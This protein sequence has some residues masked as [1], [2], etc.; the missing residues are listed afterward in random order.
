M[1]HS[2]IIQTG[3]ESDALVANILLHTYCS[4]CAISDALH[5]FDEIRKRD[6]VS[7]NTMIS[8]FLKC[9]FFLDGFSFFRE[10]KLAG[11]RPSQSSFASVLVCSIEMGSFKM[12]QQI[13]GES[14]KCGFSFDCFVGNALL[15]AY[16]KCGDVLNARKLFDRMQ[17]PDEVSFEIMLRGYIQQGNFDKA[18][19]LFKYS[20]LLGVNS[21]P[22]ALSC[23]ISQCVSS[24]LIDIGIQI[25]G[26]II[27]LGLDSVASIANSLITMYSRSYLLGDAECLFDRLRQPDIVTW[28]SL[29]G[30]YAFNDLGDAGVGLV[31]RFLSSGMRMNESTFSSFLSCCV[32]VTVL[33][34][35][36]MC[37]VLILKL[38]ESID[39]GTDNIILTMY[40]RCKSLSYASTVFRTIEERDAVSF[41]LLNGLFRDHGCYEES[42]KLC[43]KAQLEGI[44]KIDEI[45]HSSVISSCSKLVCFEMGRQIHSCVIKTGYERVFLLKNSLLEMYSQC[46][47]LNDMQKFFSEIDEPDLFSWNMMIMG[48]ARY[49][50]IDESVRV[51]REMNE[52]GIEFNEFSY[53]A[54]ID[55]CNCVETLVIGEQIHSH[56]N[57]SGLFSDTALMNSLL[58]MYSNCGMMDKASMVFE[59]LRFVDSISWNAIVSGYA[60]NG[61]AKESLRFYFLMI[62]SGLKPNDVTFLSISKSCGILAELVLGS[63]LHAQVI[64]RAFELDVSVSN[65][66]ITMYA[67]CGNIHDS[68]KVFQNAIRRDVITWNSM[69]FGYA[70][71]GCGREA[72]EIFMEMKISGLEPNEV[73][74][75]GVLCACSHAGL[76]SEAWYQ[77]NSMYKDYN[78]VPSEEHYA[79]MVDILCRAGQLR[80]AK[81]L[82]EK[83]PFDPSSLIW[84]TLLSA[85]RGNE[86]I[87]LGEEAAERIMELEPQDSAAFVL[88]SNIYA[89]AEKS[90]NKAEMRRLM[91]DRGVK[92]EV[93][94]SWIST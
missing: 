13:H 67:K 10:M 76:I 32:A 92:K 94:Y 82:I 56:I 51:W 22:F 19:E 11:I 16:V 12:C 27:K 38:R 40:C 91:K 50:L 74:F 61:L 24:K 1:A 75:V 53:C 20:Y 62:Q 34:N 18:I 23:L 46:G 66:F 5:L 47:R 21:S 42:I 64:K 90:E 81:D 35:A 58:S 80:D 84:R 52:L 60:Q 33:E 8:G 72:L 71:H 14:L 54:M 9:G 31:G 49:G 87:K 68:S 45:M 85:C 17:N 36:K 93:G 41:N 25:H 15:T 73:T 69:I 39:Q 59:E 7:W 4:C 37:H 88:L 77:F 29:I 30:G 70:Q 79:C 63:Q 86:N 26:Y 2:C 44:I 6:V 83:M 3:F 43:C 57:K 55:A 65:S 89:L 78:I 48:Y 28:N